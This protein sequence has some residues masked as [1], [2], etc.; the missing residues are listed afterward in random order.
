MPQQAHA[1]SMEGVPQPFLRYWMPFIIII[2]IILS[3]SGDFKRCLT[4]RCL[5]G[6][7][8][9]LLTELL[10][11]S[12]P[13]HAYCGLVGNPHLTARIL[14]ACFPSNINQACVVQA[15]AKVTNVRILGLAVEFKDVQTQVLY[16][17]GPSTLF[18]R[19]ER[20]AGSP[21]S[22]NASP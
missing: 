7:L 6:R 15:N 22:R 21:D 18:A 3:G 20:C 17:T 13:L 12:C 14:N 5:L 9:E 8:A 4:C 1:C 10:A 11:F 2:I 19:A 16:A